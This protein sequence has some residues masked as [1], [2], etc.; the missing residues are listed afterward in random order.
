MRYVSLIFFLLLSIFKVNNLYGTVNAVSSEDCAKELDAQAPFVLVLKRGEN[1]MDSL[2]TCVQ[3]AQLKSAYIIGLGALEQPTLGYYNLGK[4]QYQKRTFPGLYE[5][6]NL[7]GNLSTAQDKP[8][9]HLHVNLSNQNYQ[10][11]GGHLFSAK[12]GAVVELLIMPMKVVLHREQ[13][14]ATGLAVIVPEQED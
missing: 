7:T 14:P 5:L 3:A 6:T 9:L 13:D 12:V 2:Q 10:V 11:I 4:K 1:L 8:F